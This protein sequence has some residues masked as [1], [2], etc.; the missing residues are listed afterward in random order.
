MRKS[1]V[2]AHIGQA[3]L[4]A[5]TSKYS[6]Q[7]YTQVQLFGSKIQSVSGYHFF[8]FTARYHS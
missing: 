4:P 1:P 5:Y 3:A 6:P 2:A 7:T 8:D